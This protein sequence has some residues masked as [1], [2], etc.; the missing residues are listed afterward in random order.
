MCRQ[1]ILFDAWSFGYKYFEYYISYLEGA[2]YDV[3]FATMDK[4]QKKT[5]N[6]EKSQEL[7]DYI[8]YVKR[9][10]AYYD[11]SDRRS[12]GEFKKKYPDPDIIL[13]L[14]ISHLENRLINLVYSGIP[15]RAYVQHG[16]IFDAVGAKKTIKSQSNLKTIFS[17]TFIFKLYKIY[18]LFSLY[19]ERSTFMDFFILFCHW[20]SGPRKFVWLPREH[21]TLDFDLGFSFSNAERKYISKIYRINVKNIITLTNPEIYQLRDIKRS[22]ADR[23]HVV[24]VD[25]A[26]VEADL[27]SEQKQNIDYECIRQASASLNLKF[28]IKLHPRTIET[29]LKS[30]YHLNKDS[31]ED[32]LSCPS[33]FV[34][35]NSSLLKTLAYLGFPVV[36]FA[37]AQD[38]RSQTIFTESERVELG[39]IVQTAKNQAE[40]KTKLKEAITI[41]VRNFDNGSS[42]PGVILRDTLISRLIA[43]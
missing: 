26:L 28:S 3:V 23:D 16:N 1:I 17:K 13:H 18:Y 4:L 14:S 30:K 5:L 11:I 22:D 21:N 2:G 35:Y 24:F 10:I 36:E 6:R 34:G 43:E 32:L 40:L 31:I 33:I 12:L 29:R 8:R 19:R 39:K 38:Y 25:Q 9:Q 42:D 7:Q 27:L 15:L 37:P 41:D 20:L